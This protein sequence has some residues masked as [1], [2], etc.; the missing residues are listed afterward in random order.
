MPKDEAQGRF[1]TDQLDVMCI[2]LLV[3]QR[4]CLLCFAEGL[5]K[6]LIFSLSCDP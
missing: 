4:V 5:N 2:L 1:A 6:V 3:E